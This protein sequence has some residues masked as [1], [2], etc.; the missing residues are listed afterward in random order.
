MLECTLLLEQ[1]GRS[2]LVVKLISNL[3]ELYKGED[4]LNKH[5]CIACISGI[6]ALLT[7]QDLLKTIQNNPL[8]LI[9]A[10]V[11]AIIGAAY[12]FGYTIETVHLRLQAGI[13][14]LPEITTQPFRRV[15]GMILIMIVWSF[16]TMLFGG[17]VLL[18]AQLIGIKILAMLLVLGVIVFSLFVTYVYIAYAKSFQTFGLMNITLPFKFIKEGFV[19]TFILILKFIFLSI[20]LTIPL[21][22]IYFILGLINKNIGLGLAICIGGYFSFIIQLLWYTSL[23]EIYENKLQAEV[24]ELY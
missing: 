4:I 14:V 20:A 8:M 10:L 17:I 13:T 19:D 9:I 12:L 3:K 5:I 22:I 6:T 11:I 15:L 16:Y 21:L 2:L 24:E 7:D 1:K 18:F 23:A